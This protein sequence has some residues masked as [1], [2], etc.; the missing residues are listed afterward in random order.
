MRFFPSNA[1][2][3]APL[4]RKNHISASRIST[5]NV[6]LN[7]PGRFLRANVFFTAENVFARSSTR[8][9]LFYVGHTKKLSKQCCNILFMPSISGDIHF[10]DKNIGLIEAPAITVRYSSSPGGN[11]DQVSLDIFSY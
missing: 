6:A 9:H 4:A 3:R 2:T 7:L 1:L 11:S 8:R 10:E 5:T